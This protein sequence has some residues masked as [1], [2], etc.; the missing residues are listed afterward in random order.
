MSDNDYKD[1]VSK[2]I[3]KSSLP[4]IVKKSQV[5]NRDGTFDVALEKAI[6]NNKA[7]EEL[8]TSVDT[9]VNRKLAPE[10]IVISIM[11]ST[12]NLASEMTN[13]PINVNCLCLRGIYS[14]TKQLITDGLCDKI[15]LLHIDL[16][17]WIKKNYTG[18]GIDCIADVCADMR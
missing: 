1:I 18:Y 11:K 3:T 17:E 5:S 8:F 15:G 4:E 6:D 16:E 14:Q 10:E 7:I 9:K 12:L 13:D 2:Y